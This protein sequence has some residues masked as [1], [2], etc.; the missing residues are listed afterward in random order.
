[1]VARPRRIRVCYEGAICLVKVRAKIGH[2]WP[3]FGSVVSA[4][5]MPPPPGFGS[6]ANEAAAR[7]SDRVVTVRV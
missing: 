4:A 1:M 3:S 5:G 6:S 2:R 7:S